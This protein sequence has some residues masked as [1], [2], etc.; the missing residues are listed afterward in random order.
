M[1]D[2]TP[3]EIAQIL[4]TAELLR[5]KGA[6]QKINVQRFCQEAGISRKNAYKHKNN[7]SP[8]AVEKKIAVLQAAKQTAEERLK[9]ALLQAQK[10]DVYKR[11]FDLSV[12]I[13]VENKK[14]NN[15]P[16]ERRRKLIEEFNS[17]ASSH[18]IKLLN[19]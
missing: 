14:N 7:R 15:R 13:R 18:G 9:L 4:Q 12:A 10:A 6:S 1:P 5:E 2:F 19:Y 16:T 11:L 8:E 17:I 3:D